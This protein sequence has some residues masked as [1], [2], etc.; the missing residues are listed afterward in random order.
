MAEEAKVEKVREAVCVFFDARRLEETIEEL[1]SAGFKHSEISLLAG[2][3]TVRQSLGHIYT[4]IN[5]DADDTA[6]PQTAFVAK[7]GVGDAVHG[8]LGAFFFTGATVA[9][10]AVVAT[11]GIFGTALMAA[12]AGLAAL[13]GIE[14]A[15]AALI[16]KSE[17]EFL[18]EEVDRG[19]LLLF[20][21]T[22]D[23]DREAKAV[24]ILSK[25]SAFDPHIIEIP[26]HRG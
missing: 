25:H 24:E 17:A 5:E 26:D 10:G 4:E 1:Q 11:A 2:E 14:A 19:H 23:A 20:V 13:V 15:M 7:E 3:H 6:A 12:T 8:I 9:A 16:G 21:R 22:L 18:H